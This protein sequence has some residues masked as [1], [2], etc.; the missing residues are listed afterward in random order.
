MSTEDHEVLEIFR[1]ESTEH[2][3]DVENDILEI[4]RGGADP[5]IIGH[6]FRAVHTVK[7]G[8]GF[9]KLEKINDLSHHLENVVDKI[10]NKKL[11][12]SEVISEALLKGI[13]KL[14]YLLD[15]IEISNNEDISEE[16][17]LLDAIFDNNYKKTDTTCQKDNLKSENKNTEPFNLNNYDLDS[18]IKQKN[19]LIICSF[20]SMVNSE[21]S[22]RTANDIINEVR[23]VGTLID[24]KPSLELLQNPEKL[25]IED[26]DQ[27]IVSFILSTVLD[28][29][30]VFQSGL[31]IIPE[32]ITILEPKDI[33]DLFQEKNISQNSIIEKQP[34]NTVVF[35]PAQKEITSSVKRKDSTLRV[36]LPVLDK[37]MNLAGELVLVRNQNLQAV[38][39]ANIQNITSTSKNLNVVTSELQESIM[40]TRMQPI[41][42]VFNRF[43]RVV[44][45]LAKKLNKEIDLEIIG[46]EVELDK[47]IIE[48]IGDPLTH[49]V[50]NAV[51]HGIEDPITRRE[52]GK[53]QYGNL[54]LKAFH[55]SG[56]INIQI[57][58]DGKGMDPNALKNSAIE[59]ELITE[60][61]A[62]LL[63][64]KEAFKLIF[65]PGF[66]TAVEISDISG[67]GVG[68]DVVKASFQKLGGII[69]IDSEVNIGTTI[70][71]KLPLTLAIIPSL[72]V[73]VENI[74]FAIPQM[75][76]I[77]IVWLH[78]Q[79]VFQ[80]IKTIGKQE[81]YWLRNKMLKLV[82]LSNI[83]NIRK[84]YTDQKNITKTDRRKQT[85]DRR[86]SNTLVEFKEM[87]NGPV[88]RRVDISNS[89]YVVVIK[90]GK[91]EFGLI[92]DQIVDTEEIV[93]KPLHKQLKKSGAFSGT[94]VLGDGRIA[95]II[96]IN[97]LAETAALGLNEIEDS[98]KSH[99][100]QIA[101]DSQPFLLY[102]LNK[103][104]K[105]AVPVQLIK[106]VEPIKSV[107]IKNVKGKE[108]IDY[109]DHVIPLIRTENV[110]QSIDAEYDDE[111]YAI[112]PAINKPIG[113]VT[114]RIIDTI[115]LETDHIDTETI[116]E[117]GV[118]GS[119]L[120]NN[121]VVLIVDLFYIIEK[122]EPN[123]IS[124][125]HSIEQKEIKIL[126]VDDS[127]FFRTLVTTYL[128]A[129]NYT[130]INAENGK[131]A[132]ELLKTENV[133][134]I[135][136]DLNMPEMDGFEF[137]KLV[138]SQEI[139]KDIPMIALSSMN[140]IDGINLAKQ[141]G[142]NEFK[143]KQNKEAILQTID[144]L[145]KN[146][147]HFSNEN[148]G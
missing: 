75:N 59:K 3:S 99:A 45:D 132:F 17:Q 54:K 90:L 62:E 145:K 14:Q 61:K 63:S 133:D 70:T 9:L 53:N 21:S 12:P 104:E 129:A 137:A 2:L 5:E 94:A 111:Q 50:R 22:S 33:L 13:D 43:G 114:S 100:S 81:V 41:G 108:Y 105:F 24:I 58:D 139:Y 120:H 124:S 16:L 46:S 80:D 76:I 26:I 97:T 34:Q 135:I 66:S 52:K 107:N 136:S 110:F 38:A 82:R 4:E 128:S 118:L 65:Y 115:N 57:T 15:N 67:R 126:F 73:S 49:L 37:L 112:I 109:R 72:I 131:Q 116:N 79:N 142:F 123:W 8:A 1:Q 146:I 64:D 147:K 138:R 20:N 19:Y 98:N 23:S 10:R 148:K 87:R 74:C 32:R 93:V 69:D 6:L 117:D 77:E 48:S 55:A 18:V 27:N 96:D 119:V 89:I 71:I 29:I 134:L 106:R 30:D 88:D 84:T 68:M 95:L 56:Q 125:E 39:T 122:I 121:E 47:S 7:G 101:D 40:Q 141:V 31:N 85:G 36:P 78:G 144:K 102:S 86:N 103:K 92:V 130:V 44:R 143:S 60:E 25:S 83:F 140:E 127:I 91:E 28:D 11:A 113:I 35:K 51:D 42:T